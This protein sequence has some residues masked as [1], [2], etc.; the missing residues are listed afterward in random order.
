MTTTTTTPMP[1]TEPIANRNITREIFPDIE[2]AI[3]KAFEKLFSE[4]N[5][6]ND[7]SNDVYKIAYKQIQSAFTENGIK[8]NDTLNEIV[9]SNQ[10]SHNELKHIIDLV[11]GS[12]RRLKFAIN[13]MFEAL[14]S[15]LNQNSKL[16]VLPDHIFDGIHRI[17]KQYI[18]FVELAFK[19]Y[20]SGGNSTSD[21]FE[22]IF[23]DIHTIFMQNEDMIFSTVRN[24]F[25]DANKENLTT[26]INDALQSNKNATIDELKK[27]IA[28]KDQD[29]K[30]FSKIVDVIRDSFIHNE[31]SIFIAT[32]EFTK[33]ENSKMIPCEDAKRLKDVLVIAFKLNE[34]NVYHALQTIIMHGH[35]D[36]E[37]RNFALQ[38]IAK[39]LGESSKHVEDLAYGSYLL[40]DFEQRFKDMLDKINKFGIK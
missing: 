36:H 5:I 12:F 8:L 31:R 2:L 1:T 28:L 15:S 39:V 35:F 27:V 10:V 4:C 38:R 6:P 30:A 34:I 26:V 40:R 23:D 20:S 25:K 18:D 3:E 16:V 7:G 21:I 13:Y 37:L 29:T 33:N 17:V 11:H 14:F 9:S 32:D 24:V 22:P 19:N